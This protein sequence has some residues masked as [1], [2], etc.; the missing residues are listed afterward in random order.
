MKTI[1][2][3]LLVFTVVFSTSCSKEWLEEKQDI[4]L[5]VPT[6]LSDLDLLMNSTMFSYDG[7]GSM[8]ASCDDFEVSLAQYNSLWNDFNRK[9]LTWTIDEF[10]KL[11]GGDYEEEWDYAYKQIQ[12]CNVALKGL[13]RITRTESNAGQYN[14]I[15]G[16]AL[17]HR[18]RA[19]LNL[20]MT[21][22]KYYDATTAEKDLGIPLKLDDDINESIFRSNLNQ[23]YIRITEDLNSAATLLPKNAISGLHI[24]N[25]GAYA[26]LSRAY[27]YMNDYQ[28]ALKAAENSLL[29]STTLDNYNDFNPVNAYPLFLK[30]KEI[31]IQTKLSSPYGTSSTLAYIPDQLY[32]KYDVNDLRKIL[33]FKVQDGKA[34]WRGQLVSN[35]LAGT[36]T[37][38]VLLIGAEC[39]ARIG[40]KDRAIQMLNKLLVTR[41]KTNTFTPISVGTNLEALDIILIERRKELLKRGLRFQDLK[42]LNKDPRYAKTLIRNVGDK[43]YILPPND[44]RYVFPIPQYIIN[45]SGIEQN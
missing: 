7:R 39:E 16:T 22:C 11:G 38:E 41:F 42:R 1:I 8:E 2:N 18:S 37:D 32:K 43:T 3:L 34:I 17:Y 25:S 44:P 6:T 12:S 28:K 27:L 4:K 15:K 5:I 26:L 20:A 24:T 30:S 14:R 19:F 10:P 9:L 13:N 29:Y 33:Y 36:A 40:D 45:Y 21:F 31:H 35:N 23:T